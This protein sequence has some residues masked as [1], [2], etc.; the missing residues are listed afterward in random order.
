MTLERL[1]N[2]FPMVV[3]SCSVL[4]SFKWNQCKVFGGIS[5]LVAREKVSRLQRLKG[6]SK[7]DNVF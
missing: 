4:F 2:Y 7:Q 1:I 6:F 3:G 5:S